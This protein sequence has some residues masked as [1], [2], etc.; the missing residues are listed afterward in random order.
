MFEVAIEQPF[1]LHMFL[2]FFKIYY[3][4]F[5]FNINTIFDHV[6]LNYNQII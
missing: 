4:Y 2:N 5:I 1:E 3:F 6:K